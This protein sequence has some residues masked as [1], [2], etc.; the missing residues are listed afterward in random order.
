MHRRIRPRWA[1]WTAGFLG[2]ASVVALTAPT[3]LW[4]RAWLLDRPSTSELPPQHVDDA[5]RLN[6]TRVAEVWPVPAEPGAA[7]DQLRELLAR[8]RRDKLPV[9]IAGARH[10][11][12]GH[13]ISPDGIVLD[14]LPLDHL[15]MDS[16]RQLLRTG[17]GPLVADRP[18]LDERGYS[19]AIMQSNNDFSVGGS[20][21]VNCHGWQHN[22]PPIAST[23]ESLRL[24]QA[25]GSVVRC[26]REENRELFSLVLGRLWLVRR[27]PRGRSARRA[28]RALSSRDGD[29]AGRAIRSAVPSEG[30]RRV[31]HRHGLWPAVRGAGR[32][33]FPARGHPDRLSRGA[34][35]A[36]GD[37]RS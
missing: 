14:M 37:A 22:R 23:V 29:P 31:G 36:G 24:M 34:L 9:S 30:G 6:Q 21:S 7:E 1:L 2:I 4:T 17:R 26:S 5:S 12:G 19:V 10:S 32:R 20:L 18:W 13:T 8:A 15:E 11:M 35:R 33:N 25:D 16:Q 28:Q 27:D 3:Y